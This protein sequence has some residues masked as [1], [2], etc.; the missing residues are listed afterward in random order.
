MGSTAASTADVAGFALRPQTYTT[1]AIIGR[2]ISILGHTN[3]AA[4]QPVRAEAYR[5]LIGFVAAGEIEVPASEYQLGQ[6][7]EAYRAQA[8]GGSHHKI[9]I[10]VRSTSWNSN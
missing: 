10:D 3:M 8:T 5:Q 7:A 9:V 6:I 2:N 4:P 1:D